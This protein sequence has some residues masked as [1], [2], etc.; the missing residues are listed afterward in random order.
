MVVGVRRHMPRRRIGHTTTISIGA[1]RCASTSIE[2]HEPSA[3]AGLR[4]ERASSPAVITSRTSRT[5]AVK[6]R[7]M[8]ARAG[9]AA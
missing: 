9:S 7:R 3:P 1:E 8:A 2:A 5:A 4:D 6:S